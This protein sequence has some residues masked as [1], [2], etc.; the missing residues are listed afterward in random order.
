MK[1]TNI[2]VQNFRLLDDITINIE[3]D[4]TLIVG[5]NNSGKTSLFEVINLFFNE[6]NRIS[7]HDFSLN[8]HPVFENCYTLYKDEFLSATEDDQKELLE[9]KLIN[10]IPRIIL[11]IQIE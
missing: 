1:I 11:S 8:S 7:F 3:D 2:H 6:K 5:K 4:I 10:D 9:S